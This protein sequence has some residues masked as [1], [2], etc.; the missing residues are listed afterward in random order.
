M[1]EQTRVFRLIPGLE[2]A[3][4]VRM[5]VCTKTPLSILPSYYSPVSS[6]NLQPTLLAAGQLIGTEGYTAAAAGDG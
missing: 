2:K 1:G 3:E 5:G 4:F 6:L